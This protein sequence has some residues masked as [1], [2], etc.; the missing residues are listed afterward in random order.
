MRNLT[1]FRNDSALLWYDDNPGRDLT[2]K[3]SQAARRYRKK[4]GVQPDLCYVHPSALSS[5]NDAGH[6]IVSDVRIKSLSTVL[7]HHFWV[8]VAKERKRVDAVQG[9]LL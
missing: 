8:G 9:R 6:V 4:H 3:V 5:N 2:D 7:V 1:E